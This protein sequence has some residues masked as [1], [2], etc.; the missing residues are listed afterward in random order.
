MPREFYT[1]TS[2][3]ETKKQAG[4]R[5]VVEKVSGEIY[6]DDLE[7]TDYEDYPQLLAE[8]SFEKLHAILK[9]LYVKSGL[10]PKTE[11]SGLGKDRVGYK[12]GMDAM[13]NHNQMRN[14]IMIDPQ[15][16]EKYAQMGFAYG[17]DSNTIRKLLLFR[18]LIHEVVHSACMNRVYGFETLKSG[19]KKRNRVTAE[20][21]LKTSVYDGSHKKTGIKLVQEY[22]NAFNEGVVDFVTDEL[23]ERYLQTEN[24]IV[25]EER[26]RFLDFQFVEANSYKKQK[27]VFLEIMQY[28][29]KDSGQETPTVYEAFI[30][31]L[32]EKGTLN[33]E[34]LNWMEE[35][36]GKDTYIALK[37]SDM[38]VVYKNLGITDTH[39]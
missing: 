14:L 1:A 27:D 20:T 15:R 29:A 34:L 9:Y 3:E 10:D 4:F 17:L 5:K 2:S 23:F 38:E 31:Q 36:L 6:P 32:L 12:V 35:V 28:L 22:F 11:F 8:F 33:Q 18:S 37:N 39:E 26:E 21:G 25:K 7:G 30:R 13:A 16:I 24:G 19:N